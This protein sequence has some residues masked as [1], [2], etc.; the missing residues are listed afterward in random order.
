[1]ERSG[2]IVIHI[3]YHK[4][5]STWLQRE[6][7][8]KA[9]NARLVPRPVIRQELLVPHA[10]RFDARVARRNV[11]AAAGGRAILSEEE[12]SGNLHTGGL[13]GAM[14]KEIA[15]RLAQAFP[16]AHVVV[17]VRNQKEM[18][19][20]AYKQYVEGGG[21]GS[22]RRFLRPPRSPHKTP[23]FALDHF[24]YDGLVGCYESLFGK[25]AVHVYACEAMRRERE[26]FVARFAADLA[27]DLDPSELSFAP[28]NVGYRRWTLRAA[29]LLNHFHDRE[30]PNSSC[31]IGIPGFYAVASRLGAAL[32]RTPLAGR[33]ETLEDFLDA[34][35]IAR[36][37][38]RFRE[39]N[40]RLEKARALGLRA[41]GY[42]LPVDRPPR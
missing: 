12:L 40:E 14:S 39:S 19:A 28:R 5:G 35:S 33:S 41:L 10:F 30:I 1:M 37:E 6:L 29:R 27:L 8:P 25:E 11:L 17:F 32:N 9:R 42:P 7:F 36:I 3:G 13:N 21:T 18:V 2:P 22:I 20:S 4:T 26:A 24:A 31:W 23:G 15:H 34:A 38:D 16:D